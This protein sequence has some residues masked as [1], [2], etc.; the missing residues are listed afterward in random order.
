MFEP[1]FID[2]HIHLDHIMENDPGCIE[3]LKSAGCLTV[4][5]ALARHIESVEDLIIYLKKQAGSIQELNNN[6]LPCFFLSGIHPRNI[7]LQLKIN[8]VHEII[9][10][11][12]ENS[13]CLGLGEIGLETGNALEMDVFNEQLALAYSYKDKGIRVGVHTPRNNKID[14]TARILSVLDSYPGLNDITVIDH[15][16]SDT[17]DMVLRAG[18]WAGVTL[19]PI[20]TSCHELADIIENHPDKIQKI[21]CNSDSGINFYND[22]YILAKGSATVSLSP[23]DIQRLTWQNARDFFK[24]DSILGFQFK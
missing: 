6:G 20:K 21:M 2:S 16:T 17:I 19:S 7:S 22:L 4:S 3:W 13:Y 9:K 11:Y 15:C 24:P 1:S 14:M 23:G 12:L 8:Q 18:Y 10:P 5:W